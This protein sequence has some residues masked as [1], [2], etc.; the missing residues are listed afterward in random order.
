LRENVKQ[1]FKKPEFVY[2][3]H[4]KRISKLSDERIKLIQDIFPTRVELVQAFATEKDAKPM[5]EIISNLKLPGQKYRFGKKI[6]QRVYEAFASEK[7]HVTDRPATSTITTKATTILTPATARHGEACCSGEESSDNDDSSLL[8]FRPF[9]ASK[10]PVTRGSS[11]KDSMF[12]NHHDGPTWVVPQIV[13]LDN[14]SS[15]EDEKLPAVVTPCP[16]KRESSSGATEYSTL[17]R[18]PNTKRQR[19][20][21]SPAISSVLPVLASD[22][23]GASK[24]PVR[25]PSDNHKC[26][27]V[28]HDGST[29]TV[30]PETIVL[31]ENS[32]SGQD[33]ERLPAAVTPC[34]SKRKS[35][36]GATEYSTLRSPPN[37]KRQRVLF[38]PAMSS[39]L[40]VLASDG[41]GVDGTVRRKRK[42]APAASKAP[43]SDDSEDD[44]S[45]LHY[46][47]FPIKRHRNSYTYAIKKL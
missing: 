23:T 5:M 13:F 15:E 9:A 33:D 35:S 21:F 17:R 18:P 32:S 20:L 47:P 16:R 6:S 40:P 45:L 3:L 4:L 37:T 43:S 38:S 36:S 10:A 7:S 41:S 42:V 34:P 46:R 30:A 26:S 44:D 31:L 28:H 22:G 14:S 27:L 29:V 2:Y 11:D 8:N 19:V 1:G 24:A 39:V 25:G 12:N